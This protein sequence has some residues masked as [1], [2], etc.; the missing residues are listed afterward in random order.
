MLEALAK[1]Y[2]ALLLVAGVVGATAVVVLAIGVVL[3]FAV[4]RIPVRMEAKLF[5]PWFGGYRA[6]DDEAPPRE[7]AL[8]KK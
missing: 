6:D 7:A 5:S 1:R 2:E 4:S 8:A 3:N